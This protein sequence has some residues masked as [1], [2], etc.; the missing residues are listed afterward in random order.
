MAPRRVERIHAQHELARAVAARSQR[1]RDNRSRSV[2]R[3][4][5]DRIFE[6]DDQPVG[7]Q[8]ARLFQGRG[9]EPGI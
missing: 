2:L 5:G 1:R 4:Q 6:I 9:F 8:A 3:V 7:R